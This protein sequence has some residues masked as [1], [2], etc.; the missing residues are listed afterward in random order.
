MSWPR[1]AL[2]L[3]PLLGL[4]G[5]SARADETATLRPGTLS[6]IGFTRLPQQRLAFHADG[7]DPAIT[8][9]RARARRA[10]L[11]PIAGRQIVVVAFAADPDETARLDVGAFVGWDGARLRV[12]ALEVL[13]WQIA[14][15]GGFSTRL[16]ASADRTRLILRRDA[17]LPRGPTRWRRESWTDFLVWR[18]GEAL[19]DAPIRVPP[20]GTWQARL[21]EVRAR[22]AARLVRPCDTIDEDLLALFAPD[23]LP[24]G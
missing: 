18:D 8:L 15:G 3:T 11:L 7:L 12:L 5:A 9:P 23:A 14:A 13:R 2:L 17:S 1:R 21:A 4:A 22:V 6:P 20:L 19:A 16:Y 24:P 10:A